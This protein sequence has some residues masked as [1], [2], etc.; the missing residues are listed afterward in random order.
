MV[1]L[2]LSKREAHHVSKFSGILV[3]DCLGRLENL[4]HDFCGWL[5][6]GHERCFT[7]SRLTHPKQRR[8]HERSLGEQSLIFCGNFFHLVLIIFY[9]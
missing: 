1:K 6:I 9:A 5:E 7:L 4:E 3:R 8:V 2:H